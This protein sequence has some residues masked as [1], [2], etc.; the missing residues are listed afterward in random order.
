MRRIYMTRI[1]S[2][3]RQINRELVTKIKDGDTTWYLP[4]HDCSQTNLAGLQVHPV[5]FSE[6]MFKNHHIHVGFIGDKVSTLQLVVFVN[7]KLKFVSK[8][9]FE[10][11]V[12][13]FPRI[14]R[15]GWWFD[16]IIEEKIVVCFKHRAEMDRFNTFCT[17][18]KQGE[19]VQNQFAFIR[20]D[21]LKKG[22]HSVDV[23]KVL[24]GIQ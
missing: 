21:V 24:P 5:T 2:T 9:C 14:V 20:V 16:T 15:K 18:L 7:G 4:K 11:R 13:R 8:R 23:L 17:S 1:N 6:R 19:E 22:E 12:V 10:T 3:L